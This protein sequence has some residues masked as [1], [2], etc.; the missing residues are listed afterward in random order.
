MALRCVTRASIRLRAKTVY[1]AVEAITIGRGRLC[2]MKSTRVRFALP[3][4]AATDSTSLWTALGACC[5]TTLKAFKS[6]ALPPHI[7]FLISSFELA[8]PS[9]RHALVPSATPLWPRLLRVHLLFPLLRRTRPSWTATQLDGSPPRSRVRPCP[10]PS[11][12]HLAR[13]W[14]TSK[15]TRTG[16]RLRRRASTTTRRRCRLCSSSSSS[17]TRS[18]RPLRGVA[19]R[20]QRRPP[21]RGSSRR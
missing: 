12:C 18:W 6:R 19:S 4:R 11:R 14:T 8:F 2:R 13:R 20:H 21:L 10:N 7:Y 5:S 9:G 1:S 17:T 3:G 15:T 16:A